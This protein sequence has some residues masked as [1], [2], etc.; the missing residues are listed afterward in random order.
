MTA[1]SATLHQ[2][3]GAR[4]RV[5]VFA[6][7]HSS[8]LILACMLGAALIAWTW[9]AAAESRCMLVRQAALSMQTAASLAI[10]LTALAWRFHKPV[11][12]RLAALRSKQA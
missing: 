6:R 3:D 2:F 5:A 12:Q 9:P 11:M 8:S 4:G 1:L 10:A 7:R